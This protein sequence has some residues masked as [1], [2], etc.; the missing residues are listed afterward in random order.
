VLVAVTECNLTTVLFLWA[1]SFSRKVLYW[2]SSKENAVCPRFLIYLQLCQQV[3]VTEEGSKVFGPKQWL[4][5]KLRRKL[6][7]YLVLLVPTLS[8]L[9]SK[10]QVA[11]PSL[12]SV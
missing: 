3:M 10:S 7:V 2:N 1:F 9:P 11:F 6:R 12:S 4:A 5:G 8:Q